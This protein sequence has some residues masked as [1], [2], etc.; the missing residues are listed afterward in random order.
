M[1]R[2]PRL[3]EMTQARLSKYRIGDLA[4]RS[5]WEIERGRSGLQFDPTPLSELA[6]ALES[7]SEVEEDKGNVTHMRPGYFE[8]LQ[9]VYLVHHSDEPDTPDVVRAFVESASSR[10]KTIARSGVGEEADGLVDICLELHRAFIR[11]SAP[12]GKHDHSNRSGRVAAGVR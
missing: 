2:G 11:R 10:L 4:L 12:K 7:S 5:A 8:P 9:M 1:Q 6:M 3:Y